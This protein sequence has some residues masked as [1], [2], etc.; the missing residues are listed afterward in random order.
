MLSLSSVLA[1]GLVAAQEKLTFRSEIGL[2]ILQATVTNDRGQQVTNLDQD[3]FTVYENG[4]RQALTIF[5]HDVVPISLGILIDNSRSMRTHRDE[6]EAAASSAV[7]SANPED[8][9]LLIH[10]ADK[11]SMDVALTKE[12]ET[13]A[14][15]FRFNALGGTALRDALIAGAN[16]LEEHASNDRKVL[17]V[18]TD[19]NDNASDVSLDTMR[20]LIEKDGTSIYAVGLFDSDDPQGS[21]RGR[22]ALSAIAAHSGGV[23]SFPAGVFE[24]EA[25]V[26]DFSTR[27]RHRYTIGYSPDVQALDGSYRKVKVVAKGPERLRVNTRAGYQAKRQ[28]PPL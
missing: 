6:V 27:M 4:D 23:A 17:L 3:S 14:R 20:D 9:I 28:A 16:Y 7:K 12:K 26:R 1:A 15:G 19:G 11:V 24:A 25:L 8:E 22:E 21:S 13:I 2:V 18:I 5:K 10:F